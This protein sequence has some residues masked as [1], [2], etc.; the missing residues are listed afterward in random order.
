MVNLD[1][2]KT[3][4][5]EMLSQDGY[6]LYS[7]SYR[8]G[9]LEIIVD[10]FEPISL[11]DITVVSQKISDFLDTHEFC[12]ESYTLN[13]S[14]LGA[15]KPIK[16]EN[17]N[18]YIGSYVAL[19][20]SNPYKGENNLEGKIENIENETLTLVYKNKTRDVKCLIPLK[21]I[22]KAKLSIKI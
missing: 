3:L 7:L 22:D 10:R 15:E 12:E 14:S 16:L 17:L 20:L 1:E 6:E 18:K 21:D 9:N 8:K 4:I 11:D 5:N 19:H 13:V 2:L